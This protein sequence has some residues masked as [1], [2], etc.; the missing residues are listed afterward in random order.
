M[1]NGKIK[2]KKM[3]ILN[4]FV[5]TY[6]NH[7]SPPMFRYYS[8]SRVETVAEATKHLKNSGVML[9]PTQT[10]I[11]TGKKNVLGVNK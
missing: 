5:F 9:E 2:W 11:S 4:E 7:T 10:Y 8:M 1:V 3:E 6:L